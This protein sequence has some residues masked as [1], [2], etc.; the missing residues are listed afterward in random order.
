MVKSIISFR[1]KMSHDYQG[2]LLSDFSMVM[3]K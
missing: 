1:Q 3:Q 2:M